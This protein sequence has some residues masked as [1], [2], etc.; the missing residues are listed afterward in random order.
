MLISG[1]T[2]QQLFF[3]IAKRSATIIQGISKYIAKHIAALK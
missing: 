1:K 2:T 3:S